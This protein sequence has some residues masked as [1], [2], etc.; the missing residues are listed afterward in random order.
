MF[1]HLEFNMS[2]AGDLKTKISSVL[3]TLATAGTL[4]EVQEDDLK[5]PFW[6][7]TFTSFPLA[8][9]TGM[10]IEHADYET[11]REN[12]RTH[13]FEILII[14]Q[15][16]KVNTATDIEDLMEIVMNAFDNSPTLS[17][18]ANGGVEAATSKAEFI[19]DGQKSYIAFTIQIRA[20]ALIEL[21]F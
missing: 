13:T 2:T 7:R 9:L 12:I 17:G 5:V 10:S 20:K 14:Q 4:G 1:H 6:D 21:T 18:V 11:N 16:E 3:Q 8:L 15:A 19:T